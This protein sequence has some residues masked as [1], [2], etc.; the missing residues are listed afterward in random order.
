LGKDVPSRGPISALPGG[1][2]L[3]VASEGAGA[4][5]WV[6]I[7]DSEVSGLGPALAW[8]WRGEAVS[9]DVLVE[10][11]IPG[12]AS[13]VARRAA[14][15]AQPATRVWSV[16]GRSLSPVEPAPEVDAV[17]EDVDASLVELL[18]AHGAD[19]VV[20][21]GVLRGEVLGL[22]VARV[23]AGR[24]EVGVGRHDRYARAEMR[25]GEDPGSA[26]DEAVAAVRALRRP[27]APVHPANTLARGRW[28][29]SVA[30]ADPA[31]IGFASLEPV[32][33]PLPW[34][35]LP[36]AG[37]APALGVMADGSLGVAVFSV[38]IDMDLV[39]TAADVRLLHAPSAELVLAVPEGD[40]VAV[41]RALAAALV[42]RASVRVVPK[43]WE[44]A[45]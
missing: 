9:L 22:E 40:D 35:D 6:L 44:S 1:A 32:S 43:G 15:F 37:S 16:A 4:A 8:A 21:H 31:L 5:A 7:D 28:L 29:R 36:E 12:S 38:G 41:T 33:P 23:V 13:V 27:E 42:R 25:R 11:T 10:E 45:P 19:P 20:E 18:M 26:L 14:E 2:A 34:F 3:L 39:P 30:C 17:L 24:L